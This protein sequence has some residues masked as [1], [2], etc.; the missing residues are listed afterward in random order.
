MDRKEGLIRSLAILA[1]VKSPV[2]ELNL[3]T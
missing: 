3:Y 2:V 1:S